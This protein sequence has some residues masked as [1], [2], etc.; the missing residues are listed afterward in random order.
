[1]PVPV[2]ERAITLI[3]TR[4]IITDAIR[5]ALVVDHDPVVGLAMLAWVGA[6]TLVKQSGVTQ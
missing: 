3:D 6:R 2:G 1:M 4:R 5:K